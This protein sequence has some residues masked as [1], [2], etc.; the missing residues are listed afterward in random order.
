MYIINYYYCFCSGPGVVSKFTKKKQ[1]YDECNFEVEIQSQHACPLNNDIS[2]CH[3][4]YFSSTGSS[5][6]EP[7]PPGIIYFITIL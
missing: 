5:P 6:C 7:C 1:V 3:A 4:G 2:F